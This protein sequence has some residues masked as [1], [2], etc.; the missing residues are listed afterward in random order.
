MHGQELVKLKALRGMDSRPVLM[1]GEYRRGEQM[2]DEEIELNAE[3]AEGQEESIKRGAKSARVLV[4][5]TETRTC[6]ERRQETL[7]LD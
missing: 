3:E 4:C 1:A 7:A 5:A 2:V 6:A